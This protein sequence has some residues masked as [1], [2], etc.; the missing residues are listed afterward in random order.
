MTT[1][2][3]KGTSSL[4][5]IV[6]VTNEAPWTIDL[7]TGDHFTVPL[8]PSTPPAVSG[9]P[10]ITVPAGYAFGKDLPVGLSFLGRP[11]DEPNLLGYAY[12]FEQGTKARRA[13]NFLWQVAAK[14]FEERTDTIPGGGAAAAATRISPAP[15]EAPTVRRIG[16]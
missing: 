9:F 14:D 15:R 10:H 13:P 1:G 2:L 7:V 11:W 16:L 8:A 12:A 5:A 4:D 3:G 6:S